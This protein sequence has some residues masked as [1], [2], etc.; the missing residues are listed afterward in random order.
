[1]ETQQKYDWTET[2]GDSLRALPGLVLWV[3]D[4]YCGHAATLTS[5]SDVQAA[6]ADY[7]A[8]Y[9]AGNEPCAC[10]VQWDLYRDGEKTAQGRHCWD[11]PIPQG[12]NSC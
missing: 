3:R 1:M 5:A 11:Y 12:G 8:G 2:A 6:L 9:D 7:A 10:K 4:D